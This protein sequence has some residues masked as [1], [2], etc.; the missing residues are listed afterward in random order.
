MTS[1]SNIQSRPKVGL[2][3]GSGG[4]RGAAH[5]GVLQVLDELQI[6]IDL[7]AG[8]SMGA[9]IGGAYAGGLSPNELE[10]EWTRTSFFNLAK[11]FLP[12]GSTKYWSSGKEIHKLLGELVGDV[13]IENLQIPFSAV[14]MDLATGD[15]HLISEGL[16]IDAMRASS[17][18][19]VLFAPVER[20]GSYLVDG[21]LVNPLPIDV[22]SEMGAEKIIAID[23]NSKPANLLDPQKQQ[24]NNYQHDDEKPDLLETISAIT[25]VIQRQLTKGLTRQN[26][27]DIYLEPD[28]Y[29]GVFGYHDVS[30]VIASGRKCAEEN[31]AKL[32]ALL[33]I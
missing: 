18:I 23:V 26:P 10:R 30:E 15:A 17:S 28:S 16:L 1:Q 6:P 12:S 24:E 29:A 20:N 32:G 22:A 9:I 19:P 21:G 11:Q 8:A 2:V 27:P 14:T 7:I 13:R 5:I 33:K 3:L 31:A 25:I 4:A